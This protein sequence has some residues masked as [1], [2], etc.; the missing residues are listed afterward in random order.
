[1][2]ILPL[3]MSLE[4]E[5]DSRIE[6]EIM[7]TLTLHQPRHLVFGR[8]S[9]ADCVAYLQ[10]LAPT[11][12]RILTSRSVMEVAVKIQKDLSGSATGVSIDTSLV[13]E[14]TV[15]DCLAAVSAAKAVGATCILGLGGGSVLDVAKL[16]SAFVEGEQELA[17][18][19]GVGLLR[20]RVCHLVC[21]PTTSGTGSEVSPNAILLDELEKLKKA[22]ISP[23]LVPDAAFIDPEL[24]KTVPPHITA[25]T[26]LDALAH[27]LE[28][29]T[30]KFAHPM[31]DV[32]AL[33]GI[34]L[35]GRFLLRAVQNP[36]DMDAREGMS[37]VSL[38]G[39]LCLGPVN[40]AAGHA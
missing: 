7:R 5:Q 19:F 36:S 35:C 3:R 31:V 2:P 6:L 21:M 24:T 37:Q 26:G 17:E 22:V 4:N 28:A 1:M 13:G 20:C 14:P 23:H 39:G 11:H 38:Y 25:A 29:Y 34:A 8:G 16:V 12:L 18:T 30:N 33:E 9:I 27:C 32:Y 15:P 40:T 10:E